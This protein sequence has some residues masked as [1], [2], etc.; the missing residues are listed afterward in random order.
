MTDIN[1]THIDESKLSEQI[2]QRKKKT[3]VHEKL[4]KEFNIDPDKVF[5]GTVLKQIPSEWIPEIIEKT[6][7]MC[8][9]SNISE[10]QHISSSKVFM[11]IFKDYLNANQFDL[12]Y[13]KNMFKAINS[14]IQEKQ[15]KPEKYHRSIVSTKT[16]EDNKLIIQY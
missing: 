14:F 7:K 16:I 1:I 8:D 10:A 2:G 13:S 6:I 15:E 12:E 11:L 4:F 5:D 3:T 9:S